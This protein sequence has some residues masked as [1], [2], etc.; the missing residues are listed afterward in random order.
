MRIM[1]WANTIAFSAMV[2][3]NALANLIPFGGKTTGQVSEAYPNLFTP[4]GM[5][6]AIWGVIYLLMGLF[7]LLQWGIIGTKTMY[8]RFTENVGYLFMVSC[9]LNILWIICWHND[10]IGLS[11]LCIAALL[12]TLIMI[13]NRIKDFPTETF[14]ESV[15]SAGFGIYYGWII[16]ATIA[17]ISVWLVKIGWNRFGMSE[18][19]LTVL[20]LLVGALIG[21]CVITMGQSR[22]AGFAMIWA[23]VG[24]LT[25]HMSDSG[26][27][28]RYTSIITAAIISIVVM[29]VAILA[30]STIIPLLEWERRT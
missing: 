22:M 10:A 6:F 19:F 20:I 29:L 2:I 25:K 4:A 15:I 12:V 26:Y 14:G 1:R 23:Y 28:G 18:E 8:D 5:T 13:H 11:T 9:I 7:I 27:A 17:N 3:I 24:I 16:A 21:I 30:A